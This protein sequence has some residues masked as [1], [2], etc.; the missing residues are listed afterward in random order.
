MGLIF[1]DSGS[2][3]VDCGSDSSLENLDPV[4]Y[5][6]WQNLNEVKANNRWFIGK[7]VTIADNKI[8]MSNAGIGEW[9]FNREFSTTRHRRITNDASLALNTWQ[10]LGAVMDSASPENSGLWS[11]LLTAN[12]VESTYGSSQD[13]EG[14][15]VTD[16]GSVLLIGN[17]PTST[18]F[19]IPGTIAVVAVIAR[20]LTT[21]EQIDWQWNPRPVADTKLFMQV[22]YGGV[23][24]QADLSGFGNNGTVTGALVAT[25]VPLSPPFGY[26][27]G[28]QGNFQGTLNIEGSF[29]DDTNH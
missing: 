1:I 13:P 15:I 11:G 19:A 9:T 26:D 2:D 18:T 4:T 7:E 17:E 14:T 20:A 16:A 24:T 29:Y 5:M 3:R 23:G 25:H 21:A 22:G 28:W 6:I 8:G 10:C 27:L 12:M